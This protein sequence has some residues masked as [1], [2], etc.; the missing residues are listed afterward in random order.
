MIRV[1][2]SR[3][4]GMDG[5]KMEE[6]EKEKESTSKGLQPL[7]EPSPTLPDT[8]SRN[9]RRLALSAAFLV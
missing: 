7:S 1:S 5:K 9:P 4:E 6:K 2:Q 3:G 8:Y